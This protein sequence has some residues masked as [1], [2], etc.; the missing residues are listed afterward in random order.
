[1]TCGRYPLSCSDRAEGKGAVTPAIFRA[2]PVGARPS[3]RWKGRAEITCAAQAEEGIVELAAKAV[4]GAVAVVIIELPGRETTALR[5]WCRSFRPSLSSPT[6]SW[7]VSGRSRSSRR[8]SPSAWFPSYRT[9]CISW[10]STICRPTETGTF[11]PGGRSFLD[12]G[13]GDTRAP[14]EQALARRHRA[15]AGAPCGRGPGVG[16]RG[17]LR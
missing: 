13:C 7:E 8:L 17:G 10:Q 15:S 1:L 12:C 4:L 14:M 5:A 16:R 11:S 3:A 6:T 9:W 2:A